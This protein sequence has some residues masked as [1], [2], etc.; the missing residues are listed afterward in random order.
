MGAQFSNTHL[1]SKLPTQV[2]KNN[3]GDLRFAY[4]H[5]QLSKNDVYDLSLNVN[6]EGNSL[7]QAMMR[8]R[9]N[10]FWICCLLVLFPQFFHLFT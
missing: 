2:T 9:T 7:V 10:I 4:L 6:R 8:L 3:T 5:G 1:I